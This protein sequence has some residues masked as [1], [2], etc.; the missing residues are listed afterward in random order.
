MNFLLFFVLITVSYILTLIDAYLTYLTIKKNNFDFYLERNLIIRSFFIKYGLKKTFCF[1][2]FIILPIYFLSLFLIL[3]FNII[4]L[5]IVIFVMLFLE[6]L[7]KISVI[8]NNITGKINF[9][10]KLF[11][12]LPLVKKYFEVEL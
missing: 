12:K 11:F 7:V 10:L 6:I 4:F 1:I 8:Y 2:L 3:S 5:N 9:I